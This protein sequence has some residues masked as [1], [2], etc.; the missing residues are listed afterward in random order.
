MTL[1]SKGFQPLM[2]LNSA[3]KG[4]SPLSFIVI[5]CHFV[6]LKLLN[7]NTEQPNRG[8][9]PVRSCSGLFGYV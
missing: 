1:N 3:I 8:V 4:V 6:L 2:A 5:H 9:K 7:P